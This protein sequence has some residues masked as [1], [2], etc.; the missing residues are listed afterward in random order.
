MHILDNFEFYSRDNIRYLVL[1]AF[2]SKELGFDYRACID[3]II[4]IAA[5]RG[6]KRLMEFSARSDAVNALEKFHVRLESGDGRA[7]FV[8]LD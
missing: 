6:A 8:S 2:A 5:E 4:G 1:V 7:R 3:R